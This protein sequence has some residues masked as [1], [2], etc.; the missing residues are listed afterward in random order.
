MYCHFFAAD[1]VHADA[2]HLH[3]HSEDVCTRH[4]DVHV[5]V[6]S[7]PLT[8]YTPSVRASGLNSLEDTLQYE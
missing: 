2:L 3:L 4:F 5:G 6:V 7:S 1:L 8:L